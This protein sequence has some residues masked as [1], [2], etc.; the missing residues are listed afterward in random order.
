MQ[1]DY[2]VQSMQ[3]EMNQLV[4]EVSSGQK[5]NPTQA[6]GTNAALLY[7]L[8]F[9]SD[10]QTALQTAVTTASQRMDTI[11]T[12]L[13]SIGSEVQT[14]ATAAQEWSSNT[15]QGYGVLGNQ[16]A[17]TMSQILGQLNTSYAG[18]GV[19]AGDTGSVAPMQAA[20]APAGPVAAVNAVLANAVAAKGGPLTAADV[21]G[22][23]TG[24]NGLDSVF[25][26]SNSNPALNYQNAFY[27]GSTDGK[28]TT[29]LISPGQT[30]SYN[31]SANQAPF[32]SLMQGLSMLS[33][34]SA[35]SSQLDD[36]AK[37]AILTAATTQ[38]GSAQR[39]M[40]TLQGTLGAT[41]AQLSSAADT[42]KTA[43]S[44]TQSQIL[45]FVQADTFSDSTRLTTL[46]T[47]L[48]ATYMLTAQ[49]S[50]LS[51]VHYM[52]GLSAP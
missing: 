44:A 45:T 35:P 9:Q 2:V 4:N 41:Q 7:Q 39:D 24:S 5:A 13:T 43:A 26:D 14:V 6:M 8:Q 23:L 42:Q 38:I 33:L 1:M 16:A 50:Q 49:I 52:S 48:Q 10:Q 21:A 30:V 32:R 15:A 51:L 36:T 17:G 46:Q 18:S 34:L 27:T 31:A 12:A 22:L 29:V 28:P 37:S 40:T 25:T 3:T 11:Q 20:D 47:Q 19:F